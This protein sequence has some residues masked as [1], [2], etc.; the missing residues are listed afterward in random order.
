[1]DEGMY[2][3][4]PLGDIKFN[5]KVNWRGE[6]KPCKY[7]KIFLLLYIYYQNIFNIIKIII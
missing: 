7:K 1:M 4:S 3:V 6:G 5:E 2:K